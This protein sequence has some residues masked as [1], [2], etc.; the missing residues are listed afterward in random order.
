MAY[1]TVSFFSDSLRREVTFNALLPIDG[2]NKL[3]FASQQP[4]KSLYLL[5]GFT[6]SHNDWI[7]YTRIRMLSYIDEQRAYIYRRLVYGWI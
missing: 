4:L 2:S 6:G 1:L 7:S 3:D 5:N